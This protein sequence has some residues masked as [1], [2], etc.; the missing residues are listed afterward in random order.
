MFFVLFINFQKECYKNK[1]GSILKIS[2]YYLF[3]NDLYTDVI[4]E[5]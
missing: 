2:K 4:L 3:T 5:N 1:K